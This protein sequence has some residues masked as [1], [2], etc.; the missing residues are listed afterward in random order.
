MGGFLL[1]GERGGRMSVFARK[2]RVMEASGEDG[3]WRNLALRLL[4][5]LELGLNGEPGGITSIGR[6]KNS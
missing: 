3:G 2:N 1:A 4:T 6:G 5:I